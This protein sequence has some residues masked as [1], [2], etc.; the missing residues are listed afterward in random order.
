MAAQPKKRP[1]LAPGNE[2][3]WAGSTRRRSARKP[4]SPHALDL[5]AAR[6]RPEALRAGGLTSSAV[7]IRAAMSHSESSGPDLVGV[8]ADANAVG[9]PYVVIGGFA[10]S[11]TAICGP[12]RTPTCSCPTAPRPTRRSSASSSA[13]TPPA[14]ATARSLTAEDVDRRPPPARR[15]PSR[16]RRH[17]ARRPAAARLRHRRRR[18]RSTASRG[19]AGPRSRRCAA[20]SASSASPAAPRTAST[21]KSSRRPRRAA[22]RPDPRPRHLRRG[23]ARLPPARTWRVMASSPTLDSF[24]A[25]SG[26][27]ALGGGWLS[28]TWE[29]DAIVYA[30]HVRAG[31]RRNGPIGAIDIEDL[32]EWQDRPRSGWRRGSDP[33]QG[34][35]HPRHSFAR[36]R[37]AALDWGRRQPGCPADAACDEAPAPAPR[38]GPGGGRAGSVRDLAR[39][40][41]AGGPGSEAMARRDALLGQPDGDDRLPPRRGAGRCTGPIS[42]IAGSRSSG[43]A[44][45]QA[46]RRGHQDRPRPQA[47]AADSV[48]RDLERLRAGRRSPAEPLRLPYPSR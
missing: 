26:C 38:L 1:L 43:Q 23:G 14:S 6:V 34:D 3:E 40:L 35:K 20:S 29:R 30:K 2:A 12:P 42:A 45:R 16:H 8:V 17:H 10:S 41:S 39:R 19:A 11:P 7:S 28:K 44:E 5:R 27:R 18:A 48:A 15:Q 46:D 47:P 33:D 21:S 13:S 25:E 24:V 4:S 32:A 37:A 36:R 22:D 31:P 9:L